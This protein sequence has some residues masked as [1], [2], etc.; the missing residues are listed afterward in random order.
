M[1]SGHFVLGDVVGAIY[2][3]T[4]TREWETTGIPGNKSRTLVRNTLQT[5]VQ[6]QDKMRVYIEEAQL[7]WDTMDLTK[8]PRRWDVLDLID[9]PTR[10]FYENRLHLDTDGGLWQLAEITRQCSCCG[11][12]LASHGRNGKLLSC[13]TCKTVHYCDRACQKRDWKQVHKSVCGVSSETQPLQEAMHTCIRALSLMTLCAGREYAP[14]KVKSTAGALGECFSF[15]EDATCDVDDAAPIYTMTADPVNNAV[16]NHFRRTKESGRVLFP[17]WDTVADNLVFVPIS[18]DFM[19]NAL[20]FDDTFTEH[21]RT[22]TENNDNV[23]FLLL[24]GKQ[25]CAGAN[26][27]VSVPGTRRKLCQKARGATKLGAK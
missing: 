23:Y 6:F 13:A 11:H 26:T 21:C 18:P 25:G 14:T 27:W 5:D 9:V 17:I 7:E 19:K 22:C 10:T 15:D 24:C 4:Q 8:I 16:C 12:I 1:S 2:N 3:K 20:G